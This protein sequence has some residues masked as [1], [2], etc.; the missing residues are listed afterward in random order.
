MENI[1]WNQVTDAVN[2]VSDIRE[3]LLVEK[4]VLL[5][6]N[7]RIPWSKYL[8]ETVIEEVKLQNAD[9]KFESISN[10]QEP[11]E[12]LLDKFCKKEKRSEYRPNKG[13]AK[14]FAENNDIVI[15]DRYFWVQIETAAELDK[16]MSFV[17]DYIRERGKKKN[18]AVFIMEYCGSG[19]PPKKKGIKVISFD[20]YIGEYDRIVFAVLAS[21]R[22]KE[23]F[24]IKKYVAELLANIIDNDIELCAECVQQYEVFLESP[25]SC[26][27]KITT[28]KRR[29]D[30]SEYIYEK[31]ESEV[32]HLIWRSQIKTVYP[33]IEE[34]RE[35]FVERHAYAI[36]KQLPIQASYGEIYT[37]PNDVE[38]G[39]LVYMVGAGIL[40]LSTAE[41]EKLKVFKEAR[42]KLSHLSN[43]GIDE[44]RK[45]L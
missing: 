13:Y 6:H 14:F 5:W 35:D 30:D 4:S 12:Y 33:Y 3:S 24:F 42:N 10:E 20:R 25:L 23:N 27:N 34:Y 36:D 44:I 11:G 17:E 38:L 39:T 18:A 32:E 9:K 21:S 1:W 16:W 31:N 26:I 28:E 7:A 43:L 15:H 40:S 19:Q 37:S 29:S 22:I 41:Y 2:Y 8:K 45:L